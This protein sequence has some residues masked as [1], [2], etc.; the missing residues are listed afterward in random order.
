MCVDFQELLK[1]NLPKG[2]YA[3]IGSGP[4][5]IRGIRASQDID[6][7]VT[8]DVWHALLKKYTNQG[9]AILIGKI[10][11]M[12]ESA[13]GE[14]LQFMLHDVDYFNGIA[15]ANLENTLLRKRQKRRE[16]DLIDI[17]LIEKY[18]ANGGK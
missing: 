14:D 10:E 13:T 7:V 12:F 2:T 4:M 16:K 8:K 11:F 17:A 18:L 15:F 5:A 9:H 1:L 6:V 3:V